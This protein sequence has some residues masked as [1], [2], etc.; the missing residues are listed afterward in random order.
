MGT[1]ATCHGYHGVRDARGCDPFTSCSRRAAAIGNVEGEIVRVIAAARQPL[2]KAEKRTRTGCT[3]RKSSCA[4]RS[5]SYVKSN[6]LLS[7]PQASIQRH[8]EHFGDCNIIRGAEGPAVACHDVDS[9]T[10]TFICR[11]TCN[12]QDCDKPTCDCIWHWPASTGTLG[13]NRWSKRNHSIPQP[14]LNALQ[15]SRQ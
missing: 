8:C 15:A 2:P 13:K 7:G 3:R 10:L 4:Q 6:C 1:A 9:F 11:L 14:P 12:L 5:S